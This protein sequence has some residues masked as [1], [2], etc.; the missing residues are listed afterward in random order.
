MNLDTCEFVDFSI[1]RKHI[2][3]SII[4]E[5]IKYNTSNFEVLYLTLCL[6]YKSWQLIHDLKTM[7]TDVMYQKPGIILNGSE[8]VF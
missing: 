3:Y 4:T 2:L 6:F 8:Y 5:V 1:I 7:R